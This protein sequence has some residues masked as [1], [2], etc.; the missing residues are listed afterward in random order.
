VG[1]TLNGRL[2][3][4]T[5]TGEARPSMTWQ[6]SMP[7]G[8][9]CQGGALFCVQTSLESVTKLDTADGSSVGKTST[10][11][12]GEKLKYPEDAVLLGGRLYVADGGNHRVV[13]VDVATMAIL[14]PRIRLARLGRER[15]R[16]AR[17]QRAAGDRGASRAS[18]RGRLAQQP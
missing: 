15:A 18:L 13:V 11:K 14:Q 7:R 6:M 5:L 4:V 9:C 3:C 12:G 1:D 8:L 17:A 10:G 16:V 2:Q